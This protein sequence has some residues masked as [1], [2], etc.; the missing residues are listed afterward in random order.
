MICFPYLNNE[1]NNRL[2]PICDTVLW[3]TCSK[4]FMKLLVHPKSTLEVLGGILP[5][6]NYYDS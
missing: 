4:L 5:Y 3:I 1:D 2:C 6:I